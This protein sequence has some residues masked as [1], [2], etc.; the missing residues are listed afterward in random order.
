M[1]FLSA[2]GGDG[3]VA[4]VDLGFVGQDKEPFPD[5][6]DQCVVVAVVKISAADG[7]VKESVADNDEAGGGTVEASTAGGVTGGVEQVP[8]GVVE[9]KLATGRKIVQR[10]CRDSHVESHSA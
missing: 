1:A 10:L 3:A 5:V 7:A 9:F 6:A 2:D 4:A 8:G